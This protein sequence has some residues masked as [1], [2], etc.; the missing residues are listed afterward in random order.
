MAKKL[1]RSALIGIIILVVAAGAVLALFLSDGVFSNQTV[2]TQGVTVKVPNDWQATN[3]SKTEMTLE[4]PNG[5]AELSIV[6]NAQE[7]RDI[8]EINEDLEADSLA[9]VEFKYINGTQM[10]VHYQ[11]ES[12]D[13]PLAY[14]TVYPEAFGVVY[15]ETG[16][17]LTTSITLVVDPTE[18]QDNTRVFDRIIDSVARERPE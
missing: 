7:T 5:L 6:T 17:P 9:T 8:N 4:A 14:I 12:A 18:Y 11:Y 15:P 16:G 13:G 3:E 10:L 1:D 2:A